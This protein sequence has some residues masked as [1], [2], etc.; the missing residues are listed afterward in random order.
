MILAMNAYSDEEIE[1]R[2]ARFKSEN[3]PDS[4]SYLE[5]L[6][7]ALIKFHL[8]GYSRAAM[9]RGLSTERLIFCSRSTFYKWMVANVALQEEASAF[10]EVQRMQSRSGSTESYRSTPA[11]VN[12]KA[13]PRNSH[14]V[15]VP[16]VGGITPVRSE[17]DDGRIRSESGAPSA[18]P[19]DPAAVRSDQDRSASTAVNERRRLVAELN[20][21]LR[22]AA[23]EDLGA[24]SDRA[25]ARL[26]ERERQRADKSEESRA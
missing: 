22:R 13:V 4:S 18:S 8:D 11:T 16:K 2:I 5:R 19:T 26:A 24:V 12:E 23:F 10:L 7:P 6:R 1:S 15:E 14:P 25:L 9:F 20:E 3:P 21:T 17:V